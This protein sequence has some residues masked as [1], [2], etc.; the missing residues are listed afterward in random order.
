MVKVQPIFALIGLLATST[1][2]AP[3][4]FISLVYSNGI[5]SSS[6]SRANIDE[7]SPEPLSGSG[8]AN[9][10][11]KLV[12]LAKEHPLIAAFTGAGTIVGAAGGIAA[13]VPLKHSNDGNNGNGTTSG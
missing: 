11:K 5:S 9:G 1:I 13:V 6:V 7:R 8:I 4:A 10:A 2:A 12:G 3:Y